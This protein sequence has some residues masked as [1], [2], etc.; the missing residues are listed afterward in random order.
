MSYSV[1]N[2]VAITAS[3]TVADPKGPFIGLHCSNGGAATVLFDAPNAVAI[4]LTFATGLSY[5]YRIK[6][7]NA[8]GLAATLVGL[9]KASGA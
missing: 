1:G 9:V 2:A 8:G 5:P 7:V 3:D 6:R 4:S